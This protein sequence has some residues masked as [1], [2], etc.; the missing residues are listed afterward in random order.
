MPIVTPNGFRNAEPIS[1]SAASDL[2]DAGITA[3]DVAN[4]AD[5]TTLEPYFERLCIIRIPFEKFDDGRGFTLARR[6]RNLGYRGRIRAKG[7][8]ISDQ[9]GFALNCGFDE[10]EIDKDHAERQPEKYW[11]ARPRT[12]TY[13]DKL[14]GGNATS[15]HAGPA[16][17]S[18]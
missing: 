16:S 9:F 17:H 3:V 6:L 2:P 1:F 12:E 15:L 14:R 13:R 18:S 7:N 4:D 10:I 5:P 8:L 11:K